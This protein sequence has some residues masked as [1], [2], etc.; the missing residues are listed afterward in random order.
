MAMNLCQANQFGPFLAVTMKDCLL[1][2]SIPEIEVRVER[3]DGCVL[4]WN[5]LDGTLMS[6]FS[7]NRAGQNTLVGHQKVDCS[8]PV[9]SRPL[10]DR[11]CE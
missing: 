9:R 6:S 2:Q 7:L 4:I 3:Q 5:G 8:Q 10:F 11:T 1:Y